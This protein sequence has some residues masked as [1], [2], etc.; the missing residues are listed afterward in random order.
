MSTSRTDTP[1]SATDNWRTISSSASTEDLALLL[2]GNSKWSEAQLEESLQ[3]YEN[4]MACK[5]SYVAPLIKDAL[6]H[7]DHA[8]RLYGPKSVICSYNGG[9][10]AVVILHLVRAA[11]AHYYK[12]KREDSPELSLDRPRVIYFDHKDEFPEI[13]ALLRE[14]VRDCDLDMIAFEEGIS[15]GQGLQIIVDNNF[16]SGTK[17]PVSPMAFVLGTRSTDPNA[18]GQG[19]FA[20]SSHYMPPFMRV[21][22]VLEWQYGHVWHFLRIFKLPY[23]ELYD[24]GYTSLGTTKDTKPCPALAVAGSSKSDSVPRFWPA[25]MLQDWDLERA[26]RVK[27]EKKKPSVKASTKPLDCSHS[28]KSDEMSTITDLGA[29]E[30]IAGVPPRDPMPMPTVDVSQMSDVSIGDSQGESFGSDRIQRSVGL[31]VIGD[32]ILKGITLDENIQVAAKALRAQNVPLSR[33][34]VVSDCQEAIVAEIKRLERDVDVVITSGGVGPTHDDVTIKSVAVALDKDMVF[35]EAMAQLL[36]EKMNKD[37]ENN[38]GKLTQA[39]IKMATLPSNAKLRYLSADSD[40]W[41]TLQCHNIFILPGVPQFFAKKME[42]LAVYLSSQL[43]RSMTYKV[44]LS[45]DEPSIVPLLNRVVENH[46]DVCFGSYPFVGQPDFKTVVTL[47][48]RL[49]QGDARR[50][51]YLVLPK[52]PLSE[53]IMTKEDMDCNVKLALDDLINELESHDKGSVLRV[54]N[55]DGMLFS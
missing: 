12:T 17:G 10:D 29:A 38:S 34:S 8:Y 40:D 22:P 54:D 24:A 6:T 43:E 11:V 37:V 30:R 27:K 44:V 15:F 33:V 28:Q 49:I 26:G 19:H 46:P 4:F 2:S 14:T 5:D 47:E 41:P 52:G 7:L 23:C 55:D 48:G 50:N 36:R 13:L 32:E 39:Q 21:N 9:K 53:Q 31:L 20:P 35:H 42:S 25:Y 18:A 45:V 1:P 16:V 51:S 3:L